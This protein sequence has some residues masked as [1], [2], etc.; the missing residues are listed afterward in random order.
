MVRGS[1]LNKSYPEHDELDALLERTYAMGEEP[2]LKVI[3][4]IKKL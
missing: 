1:N 3:D 2:G 4:L